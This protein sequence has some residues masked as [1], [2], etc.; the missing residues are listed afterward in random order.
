MKTIVRR[1][2]LLVPVLVLLAGCASTRESSS[3]PTS[4]G[5]SRVALLGIV[6]TSG[7]G[8]LP[9][10]SVLRT[11]LR[12]QAAH[13]FGVPEEE[14]VVG[15]VETQDGR[16]MGEETN[17]QQISAAVISQPADAESQRSWSAHAEVSRKAPVRS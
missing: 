10:E 13:Q 11:T 1:L 4:P 12:Y 5:G 16:S 9:S 6:R 14:I 3:Q 17:Y 7:S 15:P 2:S 8:M